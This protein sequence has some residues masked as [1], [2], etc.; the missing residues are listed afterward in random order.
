MVSRRW[1]GML[2]AVVVVIF[3]GTASAGMPHSWNSL[4]RKIGL[5]WSDG[6]HAQS[7][8]PTGYSEWSPPAAIYPHKV[9]APLQSDHEPIPTPAKRQAAPTPRTSQLPPRN[10]P[11]LPSQQFAPRPAY[12]YR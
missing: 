7:G 4:G 5:G 10:E 1:L 9:S 3:Q 6:Y 2:P 11:I 12:W 8:F